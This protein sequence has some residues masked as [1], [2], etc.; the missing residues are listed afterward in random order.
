MAARLV[1][2]TRALYRGVP[3]RV[4]PLT[5]DRSLSADFENAA[6]FIA[7]GLAFPGAPG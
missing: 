7:D 4:K 2:G 6:A 3:R 1:A 5:G